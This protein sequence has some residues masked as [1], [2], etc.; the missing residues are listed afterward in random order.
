MR[1]ITLYYKIADATAQ[2]RVLKCVL[3]KWLDADQRRNREQNLKKEKHE[4]IEDKV[5]YD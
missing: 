3:K 4:K 1:P 2:V 5:G